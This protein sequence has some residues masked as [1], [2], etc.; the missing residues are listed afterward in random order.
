MKGMACKN[1]RYYMSSLTGF[2]IAA[3]MIATATNIS[4]LT[5]FL[6][7]ASLSTNNATSGVSNPG[8]PKILR[9]LLQTKKSGENKGGLSTNSATS[10]VGNPVNPKI[11]KILLQTFD[12]ALSGLNKIVFPARRA[13]PC[14]I[15]CTL[16]GQS[17]GI[18]TITQIKTVTVRIIKN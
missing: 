1:R 8:N 7:P 14:A 16:S 5:G 10:G 9:I 18:K 15:D 17:G 2:S 6:V 3:A 13:L 4:S 11:L 12:Y